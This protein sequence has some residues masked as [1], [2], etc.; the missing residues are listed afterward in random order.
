MKSFLEESNWQ[1]LAT[2]LE[3]LSELVDS[4]PEKRS[5]FPEAKKLL[6]DHFKTCFDEG[7]SIVGGMKHSRVLAE[8]DRLELAHTLNKFASADVVFL[9]FGKEESENGFL[10]MR[11]ELKEKFQVKVSDI[12]D[13]AKQ[14]VD[15]LDFKGFGDASVYLR[16]IEKDPE[17]CV[18]AC[19]IQQQLAGVETAMK[20]KMQKLP[21]S[22]GSLCPKP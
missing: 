12:H 15:D 17:L 22:L 2:L 14:S 10:K 20:K 18:A 13:K 8:Q 6:L 9:V 3:G 5:G 19:N 21:S 16:A 4:T 1:Q 7:I 11:S